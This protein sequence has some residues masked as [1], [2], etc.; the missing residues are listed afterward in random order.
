M[1]DSIRGLRV[2]H[3]TDER[4][5]TGCT[6]V[7]AD[8]PVTASGE[9][10]GSA[11]ATREFALLDPL[12]TVQAVDAVV[13]SGGS[14]FGLAAG[15]GAMAWLDEAGRGFETAWGNVPIV[16]GMSLFDLPV[17][18]PTV[19]PGVADGH[20]AALRASEAPTGIEPAVGV[21]TGAWLGAIGAGTGATVSKW[22]GEDFVRDAGLVGSVQRH[23]DV[24]VAALVAVN[25]WG[26]IVGSPEA[27]LPEPEIPGPVGG[28]AFEGDPSGQAPV[29]HSGNTTIGVVATNAMVDKATCMHMARGAHDGLARS[30][31]PPHASVDG[32]AFVALATGGVPASQDLLRWMSVR[33]VE[34]AIRAAGDR[35]APS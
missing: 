2:G 8:T 17:G 6:V 25:A 21:G 27:G 18:D 31:S 4:A 16:V 26:D 3:V 33:A 12:A 7:L 28:S 15:D 35:E 14:A 9:V 34:V 5:R 24:L 30:I 32:D 29:G 23:G 20:T 19:R 10:R 22:R 13:L 11:P 1:I